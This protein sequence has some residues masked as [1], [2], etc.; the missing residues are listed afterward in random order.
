LKI[1]QPINQFTT[2]QYYCLKEGILFLSLKIPSWFQENENVGNQKPWIFIMNVKTS[3]QVNLL[4][5]LRFPTS[6]EHQ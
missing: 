2:L 5:K 1:T 6:K 4:A 3:S